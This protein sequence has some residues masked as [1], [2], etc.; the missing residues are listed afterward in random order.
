VFHNMCPGTYTIRLQKNGYPL[1]YFNITMGCS[2][3]LNITRLIAHVV[4]DPCCN[5]QLT[6]IPR[7]SITNA[8][9]DS[10]TVMLFQTGTSAS[11]TIVMIPGTMPTFHHLCP[12]N[13]TVRV[14][15]AG[16]LL[17]YFNITMGCSEI[18]D[19]TMLMVKP[20]P[21]P[22]CAGMIT[23]TVR[24][25][26]TNAVLPSAT[27]SLYNGSTLIQT[28]HTSSAGVVV[29][30]DRCQGS[31]YLVV[32]RQYYASRSFSIALGCNE[33]RTLDVALKP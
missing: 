14:Q 20:A 32:N 27:V 7:D 33:L 11:Q 5:G 28:L 31:Y 18:R 17:R 8:L 30:V 13:Y 1:Q 2:E 29:F 21:T 9:L 12:G 23:V 15:R 26:I 3:T 24:D 22:C 25:S 4:A 16:Y 19:L 10:V 6:V